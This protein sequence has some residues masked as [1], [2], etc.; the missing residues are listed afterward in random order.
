[1]DAKPKLKLKITKE[2]EAVKELL[3]R[4]AGVPYQSRTKLLGGSSVGVKEAD[5]AKQVTEL[6]KRFIA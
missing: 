1:V 6:L 2:S 3:F 5:Q 4:T